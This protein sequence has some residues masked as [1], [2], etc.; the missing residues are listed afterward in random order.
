MNDFAPV[1]TRRHRFLSVAPQLA[2][3]LKLDELTPRAI[4]AAAK[5]PEADFADEFGDVGAY[6]SELH[7]K[8]MDGLL[9]HMIEEADP[10]PP[11]IDRIMRSSAAQL[12]ACLQQRPLRAWFADA[13]RKVPRVAEEIHV[14]NRGTAMMISIELKTL[15]CKRPMIIARLYGA[16]MLEAAQMEADA[17]GAIP[18]MRQALKDFLEMWIPARVF[19]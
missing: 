17:G 13:R 4:A 8:F 19:S 15:G 9:A 11:G 3:E 12:N 2:A 14:R 5:L 18:E 7:R 16:M 1:E 6:V 10:L